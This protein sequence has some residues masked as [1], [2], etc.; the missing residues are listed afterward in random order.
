VKFLAVLALMLAVSGCRDKCCDP[1]SSTVPSGMILPS[2]I[3]ILHAQA[4]TPAPKPQASLSTISTAPWSPPIANFLAVGDF[5]VLIEGNGNIL[6][7]IDSHDKVT[8]TGS[9]ERALLLVKKTVTEE[10]IHQKA[11]D[12]A[13]DRYI[14]SLKKIIAAQDKALKFYQQGL[15]KIQKT[16]EGKP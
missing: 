15:D 11:L 9:P 12:E 1:A 6:A 3:S 8:I 14:Q 16:L 5:T 4:A 13:T 10:Y 7:T 2:P